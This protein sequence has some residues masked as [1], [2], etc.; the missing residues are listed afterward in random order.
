MEAEAEDKT[1][2]VEDYLNSYEETQKKGERDAKAEAEDKATYVR[3]YLNNYE[4]TQENEKREAQAKDHF[5]EGRG[6]HEASPFSV[7][8]KMTRESPIQNF[9]GQLQEGKVVMVSWYGE[10]DSGV[11]YGNVV[12]GAQDKQGSEKEV[13]KVRELASEFHF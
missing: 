12:I 5:S 8:I 13:A 3:D 6:L 10:I 7:N 9:E 4:K 11:S 1:T 2:Y